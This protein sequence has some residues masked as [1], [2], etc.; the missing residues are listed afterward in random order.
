[1]RMTIHSAAKVALAGLSE[2]AQPQDYIKKITKASDEEVEAEMQQG[3]FNDVNEIGTAKIKR[4]LKRL[5][6]RNPDALKK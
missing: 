2:P 6:A 1:M 4:R 5:K 3:A